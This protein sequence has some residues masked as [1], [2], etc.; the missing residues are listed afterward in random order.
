[1]APRTRK[2]ARAATDGCAGARGAQRPARCRD[3]GSTRPSPSPTLRPSEQ[4]G[5]LTEIMHRRGS[6]YRFP[7][8][9]GD[10]VVGAVRPAVSPPD[11]HV[12]AL[13][14]AIPPAPDLPSDKPPAHTAAH[15]SPGGEQLGRPACGWR[16]AQHLSA[17]GY[18]AAGPRP[19]AE[20]WKQHR[21]TPSTL[22][23][24]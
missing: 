5:R 12:D 17:P 23:V 7:R 22:A 2:T 15:P 10:G 11:S 19:F 18:H 9:R 4:T 6:R 20:T 24:S 21:Q 14:A 3:R 13:D 16:T 8:Q 1:V